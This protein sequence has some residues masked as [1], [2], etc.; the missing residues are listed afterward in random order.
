M[1]PHSVLSSFDSLCH[2]EGLS[3][4]SSPPEVAEGTEASI[5]QATVCEVPTTK[6]VIQLLMYGEGPRLTKKDF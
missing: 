1:A 5:N 2:K 6:R 3:F 4:Q